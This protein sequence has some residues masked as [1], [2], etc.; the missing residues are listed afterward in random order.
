LEPENGGY[1][2]HPS[3]CHR[4]AQGTVI[5]FFCDEGYI[6]KG[7]YHFRTCDNGEWKLPMQISSLSIVA[8]TAST[9]AFIL[10]LVVL[11]VFSREQGVS[12]QPTSI[13]VEGVQVSLPS[14]EEAVYGAGGSSVPPPESRVQIV[15]SEGPQA[16]GLN[17]P[18]EQAQASYTNAF[19]QSVQNSANIKETRL[20]TSEIAERT[21]T[22]VAFSVNYSFSVFRF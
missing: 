18:L 13:M 4:L 9:V 6:L 7:G 21:E 3:P 22:R 16:E 19:K 11:F 15:L 1:N 17:E 2:C 12:G 5:E 20:I 8:S 10:L 14:Y